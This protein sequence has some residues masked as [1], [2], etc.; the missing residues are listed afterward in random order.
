MVEMLPEVVTAVVAAVGRYG[1]SV[2]T[3]AEDAAVDGTVSLGQRLIQ[4]IFHGAAEGGSVSEAVA[5]LAAAPGDDDAI[6][7]LRL[8]L[9][10]VLAADPMLASKVAEMVRDAG[11]TVDSH[12]DRVNIAQHNSGIQSSGN[13]ATIIQR[14]Q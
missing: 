12:G 10:K 4:K 9:K 2:L 7:A 3:R 13:S 5:D 14:Q 11:V 6:A 8:R 1:T